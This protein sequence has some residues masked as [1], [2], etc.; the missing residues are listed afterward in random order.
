MFSKLFSFLSMK[1]LLA[2]D[3]LGYNS[4]L[5]QLTDK[6]S[7]LQALRWLLTLPWA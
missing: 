6:A 4:A 7:R 1:V 5:Q 2:D 3:A